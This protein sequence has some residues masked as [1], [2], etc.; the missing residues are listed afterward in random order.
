MEFGCL[1]RRA[2]TYAPLMCNNMYLL[3]LIVSQALLIPT[4]SSKP[5]KPENLFESSAQNCSLPSTL[6]FS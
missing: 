4:L 5:N 6:L 3:W 2:M 1:F